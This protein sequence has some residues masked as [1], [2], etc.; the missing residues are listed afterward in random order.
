MQDGARIKIVI[1]I[2]RREFGLDTKEAGSRTRVGSIAW[3]A[4]ILT[5]GLQTLWLCCLP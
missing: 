4:I 2:E 1:C 3:K 5:V